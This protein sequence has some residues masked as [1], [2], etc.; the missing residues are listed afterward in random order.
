[1][2][3]LFLGQPTAF[4]IMAKPHGSVCN[5]HCTYCYYLEKKKLYPES[6][7]FRMSDGLL[8]LF[9]RQYIESQD[10]PVVNFIWQGGEPT[11]MG[12]D[13]FKK[14]VALQ[15]KY[16]N[17]KT[18]ENALQTNGTLIN[19][20]WCKFLYD[21]HFLVGISVDGPGMIHDEHRTNV[22]GMPS[23]DRVMEAISLF[24][25]HK[26]EFNTLTVVHRH[27]SRY[28]LEIYRF[29]K[30][31]GSEYIQFIP[32]VER[33]NHNASNDELKL[34]GPACQDATEVS[35][36]SVRPED[37]GKFLITVFDEWVRKDVGRIFVQL[38]DVTLA[39]WA[40][41][42]P[43][44][45]AFSETC[46]NA[47]VLEHNGDIYSCDHF[48]YPGYKLGNI[49]TADIQVMALS[50]RQWGFGQ[51]KQKLPACCINCEYRFACKGECPK[52]RFEI[53][54][55]GEKG[56]NYLCKAYKMFF[57][58]VHPYMQFMC[59]ELDAKRPPANVIRWA[60][61]Y[62]LHERVRSSHTNE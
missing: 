16:S 11:L 56:L 14:A 3:T 34:A 39:N 29:L 6:G 31:I 53:S 50:E 48:V 36:W 12:V 41:Q 19:A 58:Y 8:E 40:G 5:L 2:K 26:V 42:P 9:I 28:P 25:K 33:I 20:D 37:Y 35:D 7:N 52:H 51:D 17:G 1:M 23:F 18:I 32:V 55:D 30:R 27:N 59:D 54:P 47:M 21:N 60:K 57:S 45:C 15:K 22:T 43:G 49:H 4:S 46:G 61:K 13:F 44:L 10:V 24:K 62:K 38:F